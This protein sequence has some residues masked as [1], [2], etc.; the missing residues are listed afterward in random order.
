MENR[1]PTDAE[2]LA[3]PLLARVDRA[4]G[5]PAARVS[6]ELPIARGVVGALTVNGVAPVQLPTLGGSMPFAEFSHT[7]KLPTV[8]VSLVNHDNNQHGPNENIRLRNLFEGVELLAAIMTMP[9]PGAA[10]V[11]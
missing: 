11:P 5:S 10:V 7:L 9:V 4:R 8:G 6:M 1:D 2:R 3:H